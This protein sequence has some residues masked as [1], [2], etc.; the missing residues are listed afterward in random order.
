MRMVGFRMYFRLASERAR[1]MIGLRV[2]SN[3]LNGLAGLL[4]F[5]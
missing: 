3:L 1:Y 5:K 4:H 2:L